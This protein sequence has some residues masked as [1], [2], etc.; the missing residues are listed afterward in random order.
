M[1]S[2]R[3]SGCFFIHAKTRTGQFWPS[4][5]DF[6]KSVSKPALCFANRLALS[7]IEGFGLQF[8]QEVA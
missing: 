2:R 8:G 1:L 5:S 4:L 3:V 7:R 6:P